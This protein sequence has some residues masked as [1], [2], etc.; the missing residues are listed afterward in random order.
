MAP[1]GDGAA[2]A[3]GYVAGAHGVQGVVRVQLHDPDSRAVAAGNELILT[4]D[5]EEVARR[6]VVEAAVV[7]GKPGRFRVT[8]EGIDDREA[9]DALR[10][11]GITVARDQLPALDDDEFYL[12]D[13]IGCP[14][15]RIE[16]DGRRTDLGRIVGL[17]SNGVQDLFEVEWIDPDDLQHRWLLPVMPSIV[18]EVGEAVVVDLP[19]GFLPDALEPE[20]GAE[21][22]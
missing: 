1:A 17:T 9:A 2:L 14:V 13:A 18:R 7:P 4:R 16:D 19:A 5:D 20:A 15:Q 3:V 12:A 8:L 10:G 11:C 21:D 22:G 6:R